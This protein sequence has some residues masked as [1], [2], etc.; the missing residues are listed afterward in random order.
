MPA[1]T[2]PLTLTPESSQIRGYGYD[3]S[4]KTLA[5]EFVSNASRVT[6][7]YKDV[8]QDVADE[9]ASSESK[10][11]FARTRLV[12]AFEFDRMMKDD[13]DAQAQ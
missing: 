8:P 13:E 6:Y 5:V 3:P 1:S 9:F 7:H 11:R 4:T 2:I 10:G 12:H